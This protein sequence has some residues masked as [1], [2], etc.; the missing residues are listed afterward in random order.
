MAA[1][2]TAAQAVFAV[3]GVSETAPQRSC[4]PVATNGLVAT[5][6]I[7]LIVARASCENLRQRRQATV[8]FQSPELKS[9]DIC[10]L[11]IASGVVKRVKFVDSIDEDRAIFGN[12]GIH[13]PVRINWIQLI[14]R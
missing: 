6:R 13:D 1:T 10:D 5:S 3:H 11:K 14:L 12:Y 9:T 2:W 7:N 4:G 8:L